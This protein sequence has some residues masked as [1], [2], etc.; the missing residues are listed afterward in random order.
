MS[1]RW[2]GT[3]ERGEK[4]QE[5]ILIRN[6]DVEIF[7]FINSTRSVRRMVKGLNKNVH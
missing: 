1:E 6:W 3:E 5:Q 7:T 4:V 2:R